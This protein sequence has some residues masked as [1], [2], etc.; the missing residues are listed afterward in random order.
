MTAR[1]WP[2]PS[3]RPIVATG[4]TGRPARRVVVVLHGVEC[5][6]PVW[7]R[8]TVVFHGGEAA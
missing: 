7:R 3:C 4:R 8:C 6:E 2:C 5:D 1:P